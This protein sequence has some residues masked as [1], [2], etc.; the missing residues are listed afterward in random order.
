M[1]VEEFLD[2]GDIVGADGVDERVLVGR[3]GIGHEAGWFGNLD[4]GFELGPRREAVLA[5]DDGL[6]LGERCIG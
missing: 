6:G 5:G 2:G 4:E 3:E 1:E